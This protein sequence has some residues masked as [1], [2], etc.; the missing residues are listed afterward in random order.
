MEPIM[1][2]VVIDLKTLEKELQAVRRARIEA[3]NAGLDLESLIDQIRLGFSLQEI[4]LGL[5]TPAAP[6]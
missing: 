3:E 1:D 2:R 4:E 5:A 6:H